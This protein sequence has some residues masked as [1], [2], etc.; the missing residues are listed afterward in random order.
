MVKGARKTGGSFRRQKNRDLVRSSQQRSEK[1]TILIIG[2]GKE[3]EPNYFRGLR[4]DKADSSGFK[5]M[6][7]EGRGGTPEDA[8]N[9]AIRLKQ[10]AE[11]RGEGFDE[12]WCVVDVEGQEK[13]E[14]LEAAVRLAEEKGIIPCLSNPCF[15]VWLLAHF[16]R[17]KKAYHYCDAVV[18]ELNKK[19]LKQT[20]QK[21]QKGDKQIYYRISHLTKK[22][23][24]N[25]RD[26]LE[27]DHQGKDR[28][29]GNSST[30]VYRLVGKL[31]GGNGQRKV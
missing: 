16:V 31:V 21:Y 30:E 2:E 1:T 12:V 18:V 14:S 23:I 8:V 22:A 29:D 20:K 10:Q 17:S 13:R 3:T 24:K 19:W 9:E 28:L 4:D 7:K 11:R 27:Q 26:V 5:I 15:E 6:V 25:A